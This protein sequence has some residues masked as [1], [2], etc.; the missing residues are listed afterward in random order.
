[1]PSLQDTVQRL[2]AIKVKGKIKS[3]D[4]VL[5]QTGELRVIIICRTLKLLQIN[6][7]FLS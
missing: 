2:P 4:L 6:K 1:M 3:S 7:F 5:G